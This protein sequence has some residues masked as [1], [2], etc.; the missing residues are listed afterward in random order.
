MMY[1]HILHKN[2][3]H[4]PAFSID[5]SPRRFFITRATIAIMITVIAIDM[6]RMT[7]T[8]PP[9]MA[10]VLSEELWE[11]VE[12]VV[13]VLGAVPLLVVL[14][15][16]VMLLL[17]VGSIVVMVLLV[18]GSVLGGEHS[19]SLRDEIATEH[20]ESTVISTPVT[21]ILAPPL[22]QSS[23]R[24]MSEPLSVSEVPSSLARYVTCVGDSG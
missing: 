15:V 4:L 12:A 2:I 10:A 13:S 8:T 19:L 3:T 11:M 5:R 21:M 16:V 23:I 17:V 1:I 9:I 7:A 24:E 6:M 20:S 18:V 14:S 22:T